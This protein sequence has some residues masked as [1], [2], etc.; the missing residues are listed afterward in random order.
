MSEMYD[1]VLLERNLRPE[2]RGEV[3]EARSEVTQGGGEVAAG[4]T[5]GDGD[6]G[7]E[8]VRVELLNASCGDRLT[9][10]LVVER[11]GDGGRRVVDGRWNGQGCAIAQASA[12]LMVGELIGKTVAET[13]ELKGQFE[14]MIYKGEAA[15]GLGE[16]RALECVA[17]MPARGKCAMLA[18]GVVEQL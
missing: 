7:A 10:E 5:Q 4:V 8:V 2:W 13:Q 18:W 11:T 12:D 9:V 16:L 17:R 14:K 3:G 1:E 15:E 6:V